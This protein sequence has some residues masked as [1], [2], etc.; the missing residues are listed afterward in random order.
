[1]VFRIHPLTPLVAN[2]I[3]A[4]EVV[5][6][7]ASIVKELIENSLDAQAQRI[8]VRIEHGGLKKISVHDN[9]VGLHPDDLKLALSRH[10]T[11]KIK[12]PEDLGHIDTLGFRGEALASM[13]SVARVYLCSSQPAASH[14]QRIEIHGGEAIEFGPWAH[15]T[16]TT[17]E[18][19]DLFFNTPAR[20]KFLKSETT[21]RK[22][23]DEVIRRTSLAN[24]DVSFEVE[25]DG[26]SKRLL[27][28]ASD[29]HRRLAQLF[30]KNFVTESVYIE[31]SVG[32]FTLKGWIGLPTF[33]RSQ[34]DNQYFFV[35]SRCVNDKL[36]SHAVRRAYRDVMFHGRHPVFALYLELPPSD[37]DINVHPTKQE[38]RFVDSRSVHNFIFSSV[39]R[40]LRDIRP[41][42]GV[43]N[44]GGSKEWEQGNLPV[45]E[46][47]ARSDD[48]EFTLPVGGPLE[49]FSGSYDENHNKESLPPMG[50]A[51][52]QLHGIFL[53]AQN[54]DGLILVDIHAAHERIVYEKLKT[55]FFGSAVV[56]QRLLVPIKVEA[57]EKEVDLFDS[58]SQFFREMGLVVD[59]IGP[60]TLVVRSMPVLLSD[61]NAEMLLRDILSDISAHGVSDRLQDRKEELLA[62]MACHHSIRAH[63]NMSLPEMNALL[64]EMEQTENAGQCNHGRPTYLVKSLDDLNSMF[65]RGR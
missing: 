18:V 2:Q 63:R 48:H 47:Q 58:S 64:R 38:V 12:D 13:V 42:S 32:D 23:I 19:S 8:Q 15:P 59:R 45:E 3:A 33:S 54:N 44:L 5:E 40:S 4:G 49:S 6:R 50:Y 14:G 62:T 11:S 20:R 35:N 7:P 61:D 24:F 43:V 57:T 60:K 10:A 65:L 55:Q 26:R 1:M 30:G 46:G 28:P 52:G 21:E 9:G 37:L 31:E 39:S 29:S 36:V 25:H 27:L 17:V 22:H 56:Q 34:A 53:L 51:I 41:A 16:G